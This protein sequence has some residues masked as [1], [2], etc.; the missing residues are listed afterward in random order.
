MSG[1]VC[2]IGCGAM[3]IIVSTCVSAGVEGM[4]LSVVDITKTSCA[5]AAVETSTV[6]VFVSISMGI[7][8]T[9]IGS[10]TLDHPVPFT[11]CTAVPLGIRP[12]S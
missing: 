6:V 3:V 12:S 8:S 4:D 5:V 1:C 7:C 10:S 9:V 11:I 2:K